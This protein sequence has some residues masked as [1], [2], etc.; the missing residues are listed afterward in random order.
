MQGLP[1][2]NRLPAADGG[3]T[4]W[5]AFFSASVAAHA[6]PPPQLQLQL[7]AGQALLPWLGRLPQLAPC[8]QPGAIQPA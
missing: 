1:L 7:P 4:S 3:R 6:L 8:P 5:A 2:R